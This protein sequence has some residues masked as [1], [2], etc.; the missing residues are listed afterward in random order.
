MK[1]NKQKLFSD[2]K[3]T[4]DKT[5]L[6]LGPTLLKREYKLKWTPD[7]PTLGY[8]YIVCEAVKH[9][10]GEP[11]REYFVNTF[12]GPH[13][14]LVDRNGDVLDFTA[15]QFNFHVPYSKAQKKHF[16]KGSIKTDKGFILKRGYEFA[17][18]A[19]LFS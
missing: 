17:K 12:D 9:F 4:I 18:Q 6:E 5:C 10:G 14:F 2:L 19:K 8:C 3:P 16:Y 11:L 7:N 1:R 13:W 15:D